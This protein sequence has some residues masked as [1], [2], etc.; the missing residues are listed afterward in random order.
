[1]GTDYLP[2]FDSSIPQKISTDILG[3]KGRQ[4]AAPSNAPVVGANH[5]PGK[6]KKPPKGVKGGG[7]DLASRVL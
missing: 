7:G 1:V 3:A 4:K 6:S 2:W 5:A